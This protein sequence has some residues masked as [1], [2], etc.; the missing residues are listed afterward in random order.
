MSDIN[1]RN[2][3]DEIREMD[4]DANEFHIYTYMDPTRSPAS[5]PPFLGS[6]GWIEEI[7]MMRKDQDAI[8][9]SFFENES[10]YCDIIGHPDCIAHV[11]IHYT[12]ECCIY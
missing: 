3:V 10:V 6:S 11:A 9:Y 8:D 2:R 7:L 12:R 1:T 4:D 5:E